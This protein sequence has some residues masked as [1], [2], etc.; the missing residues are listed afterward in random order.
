[1]EAIHVRRANALVEVVDLEVILLSAPP[2]RL[3]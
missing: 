1:M 2:V 3:Q